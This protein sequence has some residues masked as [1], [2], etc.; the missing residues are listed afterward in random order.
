MLAA[1]KYTATTPVP[2]LDPG[3]GKTE[4][5][6]LWTYV[7]DDRPAGRDA[8]WAV[9]FTYSEDRKGEHPKHHLNLFSG[10][11]Q[12]DAYAGFHHLYEGGRI[13]EAACW[14]HVQRNFFDIHVAHGSAIAGEAIQRIGKLYDIE[15]EIRGQAAH[16]RCEIRQTRARPPDG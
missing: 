16:L 3:N 4:M 12:A 15:R 8:A 11:L 6:R 14:A 10:V 13:V 9:W 7:R 5:A 2:V 1:S